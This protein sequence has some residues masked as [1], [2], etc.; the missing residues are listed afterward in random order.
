VSRFAKSWHDW[1]VRS[2]VRPTLS[3]KT[4]QPIWKS[5]HIF[6]KSWHDW[7][8]IKHALGTTKS[9]HVD[10]IVSRFLCFFR[11]QIWS[12]MQNLAPSV[13][14]SNWWW[15]QFNH[16]PPNCSLQKGITLQQTWSSPSNA[17]TFSFRSILWTLREL[18]RSSTLKVF[19]SLAYSIAVTLG[20][21][22]AGK[23]LSILLTWS[24][25]T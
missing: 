8:P 24:E 12:Q 25:A 14:T 17:W 21:H 19:K 13:G 10:E 7:A 9:W 6:Q 16:Q 23:L 2:K 15:R 22:L 5:C 11:S 4:C 18:T 1:C 20:L 3:W